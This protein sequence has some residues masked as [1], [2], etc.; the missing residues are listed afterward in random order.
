MQKIKAW[1]LQH[2]DRNTIFMIFM[3]EE[4][5]VALIWQGETY[6]STICSA[7]GNPVRP[8]S[9]MLPVGQIYS[10]NAMIEWD[11]ELNLPAITSLGF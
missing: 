7:L 5:R 1:L 2:I 3:T 8:W 4:E 10:W 6:V 11:I 9:T